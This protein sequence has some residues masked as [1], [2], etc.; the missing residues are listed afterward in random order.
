[1]TDEFYVASIYIADDPYAFPVLQWVSHPLVIISSLITTQSCSKLL[2]ST[3][4]QDSDPANGKKYTAVLDMNVVE[5]STRLGTTS[6]RGYNGIIPGPMLVMEPCETYHITLR[7][8][9]QG[10]PQGR[11]GGFNSLKDP[12]VTNLH[13]HGLHVSS[14]SPADDPAIYIPAE[15]EFDYVISIQCDH[16]GGLHW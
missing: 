7:N 9:M 1:M 13:T 11:D 12:Y 3:L 2:T 6:T 4:M 5:Y 16:S 14:A 8:R 10:Y 15:Y